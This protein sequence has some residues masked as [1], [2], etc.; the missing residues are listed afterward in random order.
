[1]AKISPFLLV[2]LCLIT[3]QA[4]AQIDSTLISKHLQKSNLQRAFM[5]PLLFMGVGTLT[6]ADIDF[7]GRED[8]YEERN[9]RAS[10]FKTHVD[11][12]LQYS[13]IAAVLG[14]NAMG[15]KGKH[16]FTRQMWLLVKSELVMMAIVVPLKQVTEVPRPDGSNFSSFPSGHTAQAFVAATFIHKEYGDKNPLYSVL[17]FGSA[18]AVGALRILNNRHWTT[19]VF[20]GAAIGILSTNLVYLRA[21]REKIRRPKRLNIIAMPIYQNGNFGLGAIIPLK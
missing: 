17:G 8:I 4:K 10:K 21:D 16:S 6:F 14:L 5:T 3:Y 9:E 1:M 7:I 12:Y 11:D 20:F 2:V 19:D 15:I 13:P 18:T